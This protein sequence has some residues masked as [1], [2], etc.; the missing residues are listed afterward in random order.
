MTTD[1]AE[2]AT[3]ARTAATEQ[4][5]DGE[6]AATLVVEFGLPLMAARE[7]VASNADD[8]L[9]CRHYGRGLIRARLSRLA[10]GDDLGKINGAHL[11][12]LD[13]YGR[14]YLNLDE[15]EKAVKVI[16]NAEKRV[17][18]E[19]KGGKLKAVG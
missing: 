17:A 4:L 13:T 16:E 12:A 19:A 1:A 18:K 2:L 8:L 6:I 3:R 10:A 9:V 7:Y 11:S 14:A 15:H 5:S